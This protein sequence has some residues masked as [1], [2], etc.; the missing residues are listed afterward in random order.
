MP[1]EML[2]GG[3]GFNIGKVELRY[4]KM[5]NGESFIFEENNVRKTGQR[6]SISLEIQ[7]TI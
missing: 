4:L 6:R 2:I 3:F 5:P 1:K 7:E